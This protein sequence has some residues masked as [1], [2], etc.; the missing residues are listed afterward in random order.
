MT[1]YFLFRFNQAREDR[2]RRNAS[3]YGIEVLAPRVTTWRCGKRGTKPKPVA[4]PAYHS[5]LILGFAPDQLSH[6]LLDLHRSVRPMLVPFDGH[7][8]TLARIPQ[9]EID[10]IKANRLFKGASA[11]SLVEKVVP[12]PK[13]QK[14]EL[15][16][17]LGGAATGL[18]GRV[19]SADPKSREAQVEMDVWAAKLT[20]SYDL[21]E[22]AA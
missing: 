11:A 16:R 10:A 3:R 21:L 2:V 4:V 18:E 14:S 12:D 15:V 5:Y 22:R 20:V 17:I 7:E 13:Y 9:K 1:D 6:A 8:W 19:I